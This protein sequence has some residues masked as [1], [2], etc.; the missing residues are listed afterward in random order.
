MSWRSAIGAAITS[1]RG[2]SA[3]EF[4][5]VVTPLTL[6]IMAAIEF[7]RLQWTRNALQE[8]A[9]ASARCIGMKASACGTNGVYDATKST[10]YIKAEGT[11]WSVVLGDGNIA[12]TPGATC[13]GISGFSQVTLS[14]TFTSAMLGNASLNSY[15]I[16][17]TACFPNRT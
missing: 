7:A 10:T 9:I 16:Y 8:I 15:P 4:A 5:L 2:A 12:V 3:L 17:A 14:Y 6:M 1:R 13:Q 11:A